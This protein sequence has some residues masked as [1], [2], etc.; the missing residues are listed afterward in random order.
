M[1]KRDSV[2]RKL[3]GPPPIRNPHARE[4]PYRVR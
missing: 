1:L 4:E 2:V 3:S